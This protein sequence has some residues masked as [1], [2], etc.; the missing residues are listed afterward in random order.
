[1]V[2]DLDVT[3]LPSNLRTSL[4]INLVDKPGTEIPAR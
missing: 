1:M 4:R 2:K 3:S